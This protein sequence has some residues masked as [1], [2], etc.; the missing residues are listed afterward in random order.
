MA[1]GKNA[2]EWSVA[3]SRRVYGIRHWGAGYYAINEAG[4]I[5]VRPHGPT[6]RPST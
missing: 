1:K 6:A 4:N 2:D 3:D 5:E